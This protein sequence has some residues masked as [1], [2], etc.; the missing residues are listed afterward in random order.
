MPDNPHQR[1]MTT[2][3]IIG[4]GFDLLHG[5]PT[6]YDHFY[7]FAKDTLDE[8]ESYFHIDV[9]QGGPWHDF[10]NSL[11]TFDGELF[12]EAHDNSDVAAEDFRTSEADSLKDE[13]TEQADNLVDTIRELFHAWI[14]GIDISVVSK[15]MQFDLNDRFLTFNYT[16]TLQL[17]YGIDVD[18]IF[19]IHG[20][21]DDFDELVFG[22]RET[23]EEKPELDENGDSN[24]TL[25][26]DAESASEYPFY[27]FQKPVD[28]LIA[29]NREYFES[30]RDITEI[31]V[32]G[33]S[34]N[35]IDLPYIKK[36]AQ[37]VFGSKW[38]VYYH[39]SKDEA[40]HV[41]QLLRCDVQMEDIST[42]T[43]ADLLT[44]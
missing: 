36:V 10:E 30:L 44:N 7:E 17:V 23:M 14:E 24:R 38:S 26:S 4:N 6:R 37:S 22:H 19:H 43:D 27:A 21:S 1:H 5:L 29:K 11:G 20:R 8:L 16:S 32:L 18:N 31:R 12:Y 3:Y 28:D 35:E 25:F 40:H 9:A 2:L 39:E 15:K 13:L 41:Q 33:H 34:L 42:Y